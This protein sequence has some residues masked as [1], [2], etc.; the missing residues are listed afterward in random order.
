MNSKRIRIFLTV[1]ACGVSLAM[2]E[3]TSAAVVYFEIERVEPFA[4]GKEFGQVGPYERIIGQV[5]YAIDPKLPQ[6]QLIRDLD[7]APRN[8]KG[9]VEFRADLFVLVPH[10]RSRSNGAILHDVNNR[11]NKLALSFFNS[12]AGNRKRSP[13]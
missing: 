13:H 12:A 1:A 5:H 7:R 8:S 6:N 3:A 11:G 2:S 4:D 10:D 9:L